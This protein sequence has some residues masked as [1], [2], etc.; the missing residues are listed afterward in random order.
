MI[1]ILLFRRDPDGGE[2]MATAAIEIRQPS[3]EIAAAPAVEPNVRDP[4]SPST[5]RQLETE[6]GVTVVRPGADVPGAIV[7]TIPDSGEVKLAPAP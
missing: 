4:R 2:P 7:I 1:A 3:R 5:A 6:S